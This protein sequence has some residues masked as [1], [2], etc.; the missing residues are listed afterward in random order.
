MIVLFLNFIYEIKFYL[1]IVNRVIYYSQSINFFDKRDSVI[2]W[3]FIF[4][5]YIVYDLSGD[6]DFRMI[7]SDFFCLV[8]V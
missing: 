8:L 3:F 4:K 6:E 5:I 2:D 1:S 7:D